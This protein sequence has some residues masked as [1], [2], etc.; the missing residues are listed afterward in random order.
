MVVDTNIKIDGV[1]FQ[2]NGIGGQ[3]FYQV[4]FRYSEKGMEER[5]LIGVLTGNKT[6]CFVIDPSDIQNHWRGD[7]FE[8]ELRDAVI[9]HYAKVR[10]R[11]YLE[12]RDIMNGEEIGVD[13]W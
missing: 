7:N 13:A 11:S 3:P 2:R 1:E 10:G 12:Q 6:Y 5:K 9:N 4:F 8:R